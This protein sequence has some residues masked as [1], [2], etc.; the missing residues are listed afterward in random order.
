MGTLLA[1]RLTTFL[2][3][4]IENFPSDIRAA[5]RLH[6]HRVM[7]NFFAQSGK[8]AMGSYEIFQFVTYYV[9]VRRFS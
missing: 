6:W 5:S 4:R 7:R 1:L 3:L 9:G 2:C 8:L